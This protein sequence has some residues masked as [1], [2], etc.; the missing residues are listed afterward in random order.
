MK[1]IVETQIDGRSVRSD[2]VEFRDAAPITA[3][4]LDQIALVEDNG[5]GVRQDILDVISA[6]IQAIGCLEIYTRESLSSQKD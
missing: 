1:I 6:A 3:D 4:M 5:A 2:S